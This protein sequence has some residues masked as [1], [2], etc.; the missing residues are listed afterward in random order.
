M[1]K[2]SKYSHK[3]AD[4][5][6]YGIFV[7]VPSSYD[8][9]TLKQDPKSP[10]IYLKFASAGTQSG[11]IQSRGQSDYSSGRREEHEEYH[12]KH[13]GHHGH[14]G[15]GHEG[16]EHESREHE[17]RS[18]QSHE[19]SGDPSSSSG[20]Y[21]AAIN[22]RS[23][24]NVDQGALV[25]WINTNF[26]HPI[27]QQ[28]TSLENGFH[29]AQSGDDSLRLDFV[30]TTPRL[31]QWSS[32]RIVNDENSAT[33]GGSANILADLDPILQ[34]AISNQ[35]TIYVFGTSY[36]TGI[37]DIHMNQ[38]NSGH[39]ANSI[40]SDGGLL[41]RSGNSWQAVFLAF[42]S[43]EVPTNNNGKPESGAQQVEALVD[44]QGS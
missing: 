26:S 14:H 7:G 20:Q 9:Q 17:G 18:G 39:Y 10:H 13:H 35:S 30:R 11:S 1:S 41:I 4:Q 21:E 29:A 28:L 36:G 22:V 43:Q 23:T 25:A 6:T 37:D 31:F 34:D 15:H 27:T 16:R 33:S 42:A 8:Q 24:D 38:G 3:S 19:S 12:S 2:Y 5:S 40:Y 32:G 44:G